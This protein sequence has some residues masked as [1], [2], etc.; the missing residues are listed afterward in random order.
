VN[1]YNRV[2]LEYCPTEEMIADIITKGLSHEQFH[3]LCTKL[4]VVPM[5]YLLN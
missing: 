1:C 2:N 5:S 4:S 3:D